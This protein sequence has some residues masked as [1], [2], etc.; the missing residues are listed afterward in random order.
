MVFE[1][2]EQFKKVVV[3]YSCEYK[4]R[5]KLKPNDKKKKRIRVKFEDKKCKW[6]LF[7][8]IDKDSGD[9]IVKNYSPVHI[10]PQ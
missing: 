6:L 2:A 9:F 1:S 5:L 7:A 4:T 10:C 3:D 8:S